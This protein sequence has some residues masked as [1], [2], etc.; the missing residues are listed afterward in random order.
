MAKIIPL[1]QGNKPTTKDDMIKLLQQVIS[2]IEDGKVINFCI[3]ANL[4]DGTVGTG[5]AN[6]DVGTSQL[7]IS[8]LEIDV[9]F[10]VV[11][12]NADRLTQ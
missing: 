11:Q 5:W 4:N 10:R 1:L 8:H 12:I 3:A 7:L 2:D 6:A 9:M